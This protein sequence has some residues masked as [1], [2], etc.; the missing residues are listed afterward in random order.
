MIDNNINEYN[1]QSV[2]ML[3]NPSKKDF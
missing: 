3:E 1:I 2:V